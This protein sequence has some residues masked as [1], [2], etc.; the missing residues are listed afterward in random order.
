M[1]NSRMPGPLG[2]QDYAT[3]PGGAWWCDDSGC[4]R[5]RTPGPTGVRYRRPV[6]VADARAGKSKTPPP[7]AKVDTIVFHLYL[8]ITVQG[9]KAGDKGFSAQDFFDWIKGTRDDAVPDDGR[10]HEWQPDRWANLGINLEL[11]TTTKSGAADFKKSLQRKGAVV[12]YLGHSVLDQY[13]D[14]RSLGLTPQGHSKPEIP[15]EEL[16]TLLKKST[17]SLVIIASCDSMTS[18]GKVTSG[19][20]VIVTDSGDDRMTNTTHWAHALGAFFFLLIGLELDSGGQPAI[21]RK[22]GHATIK[23][24]LDV[25]ADAFAKAGTNDRFKLLN[26]D[27]S[28]KIFP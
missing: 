10:I 27:G 24:A 5:G 25:S 20:P 18:V 23:E 19:P 8:P 22:A 28:L 14:N 9:D 26:S 13:H 3:G 2:G 7:L 16:R 4:R 17:A 15:S 11:K 1:A 6:R 12:V 21:Q